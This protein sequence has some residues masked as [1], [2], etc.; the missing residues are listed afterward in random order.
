MLTKL[1]EGM[2]GFATLLT[3]HGCKGREL[4]SKQ[5]FNEISYLLLYTLNAT[6]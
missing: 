5:Y 3:N 4:Q 2:I 1:D 6:H